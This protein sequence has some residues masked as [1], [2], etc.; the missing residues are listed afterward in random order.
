MGKVYDIETVK[1]IEAVNLSE[2]E[3]KDGVLFV[4]ENAAELN[5][6]SGVTIEV[7]KDE[8]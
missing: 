5:I 3:E 6:A 8:K 4:P 7:T 2:A 1:D